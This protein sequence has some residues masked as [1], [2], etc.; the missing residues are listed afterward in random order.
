[1]IG[2]VIDRKYRLEAKIGFGG[3]GDVYRASRLLIGDEVAIKILHAA[4]VSDP[5]AGER[6]PPEAHAPPSFKHPNAVSIYDFG[7][8]SEGLVYLVMELV[9]GQNL[10]Q[11]I[12]QQGPLSP[13][14]VS[15]ITNQVCSALQAAHQQNVVHRDLKPD[16]IMVNV[17]ISG[18]RLKV[19][20]FGIA[21][22]RDLAASNLTVT[23]NV[24]G[25][26]HYMSPEQCLGEE[27]DNRSDL[28]SLGVVMY[29]MLTGTLH[30]NSSTSTAVVMQHVNKEPPSLRSINLSI[31][32]A[33][34]AVVLHALA[35]R[36]EDRP[37]S[38]EALA[39][40]LAVAMNVAMA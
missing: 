23:G 37:Q 18:L 4:Q 30:F 39:R 28:Y 27:I 22:L 9:E 12:K 11:I 1:M 35:K 15:E 38:A 31:S 34:E 24:M 2:Y 16:N 17:T 3:M 33:V 25:T 36:R 20:D 8:T 21:K 29:Q 7:V 40:E 6:F 14:T 26:P 5:Q 19:L 10:R 32:P 13:A